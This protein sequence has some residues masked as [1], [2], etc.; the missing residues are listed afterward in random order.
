MLLGHNLGPIYHQPDSLQT[1]SVETL[2][3]IKN[4]VRECDENHQSCRE[5]QR[6]AGWRP[7]R[8]LD[9]LD[10]ASV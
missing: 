9:I 1:D 4:W 3:Q 6:E 7:A 10:P 8:L 5:R 2:S